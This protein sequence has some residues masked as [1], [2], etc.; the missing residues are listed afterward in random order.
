MVPASP[1]PPEAW[2]LLRALSSGVRVTPC[3]R[4]GG[5]RCGN[6]LGFQAQSSWSGE[7]SSRCKQN[8][9]EPR[10]TLSGVCRANNWLLS[11]SNVE[12]H[13]PASHTDSLTPS[14]P[15]L[16]QGPLAETFEDRSRWDG[17][18]RGMCSGHSRNTAGVG[19]G[20]HCR[21]IP[22]KSLSLEGEVQV[23]F[24]SFSW[25]FF[26]D[27]VVCGRGIVCQN[28]PLQGIGHGTRPYQQMRQASLPIAQM[29][30]LFCCGFV[31]YKQVLKLGLQSKS[32]RDPFVQ[33]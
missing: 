17:A 14:R 4:C 24:A 3:C 29:H 16:L 20:R 19:A 18:P 31:F 26:R 9:G 30:P 15:F 6:R 13:L 12:V 23:G 2:L 1:S 22:M 28:D 10:E 25:G 11:C 32:L 8:D 33:R 7:T 27:Q 21:R 5:E